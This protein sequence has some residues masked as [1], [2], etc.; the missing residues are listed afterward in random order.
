MNTITSIDKQIGKI[1]QQ[2]AELG[3]LHPGS[4]SLQQRQRGADK[5]RFNQLSYV[6]RGQS[7]T[8]YVR[9]EDVEGVREKLATHHRLR[10]LVQAWLDLSVERFQ[11]ERAR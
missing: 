8:S 9:A 7:H 6:H 5:P 1:K 2:L 3:P 4:L 10:D 11:L